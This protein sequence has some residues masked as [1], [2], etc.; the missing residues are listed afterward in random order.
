M[1]LDEF[2]KRREILKSMSDFHESLNYFHQP[3]LLANISDSEA[4]IITGGT[5][6][7]LPS[8]LNQANKVLSDN[9]PGQAGNLTLSASG[10]VTLAADEEILT[11]S[12]FYISADG[13]S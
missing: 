13:V 10:D 5:G 7:A 9:S 3:K 12:R 6:I 11:S 8:F 2:T 1:R 4:S